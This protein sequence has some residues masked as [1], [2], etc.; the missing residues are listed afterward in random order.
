MRLPIPG[1]AEVVQ[2]VSAVRDGVGDALGLG[3]RLLSLLGRTE[4][5]LARVTGIL[6]R[7]EAT[8]D[9]AEE[10]INNVASTARSARTVMAE[11]E[12]TV[13]VSAELVALYA[14]PVRELAPSLRTFADSVDPD[15]VAAMVGLVDRLPALL[16]HLDEEVL[17][18]LTTLDRVAPDLHQ[19]L[20]IA[21]D[22][23]VALGGLPGMGWIRKRADKE[24]QEAEQQ[25]E[26][27]AQAIEARTGTSRGGPAVTGKD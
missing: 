27:Q 16:K 24:E 6:D 17:P 19:L 23:Q 20:E 9:R 3:P 5:M 2:A 10:V 15:E 13:S 11:A 14:E 26:Q 21:Q 7:M 8:V 25:A 4:A 18:I 1:S 12:G 22:L